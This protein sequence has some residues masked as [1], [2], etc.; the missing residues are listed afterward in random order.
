VD[1]LSED[2]VRLP[3]LRFFI[4][5]RTDF[6]IG[7]AF[8]SQRHILV[9]EL[10]VASPSNNDDIMTFFKDRMSSIR[11]RR[12]RLP[13]ASDWPGEDAIRSLTARAA[14]L[15]LFAATATALIDTH[16]P[17][18]TLQNI[19]RDSISSD[20]QSALDSLYIKALESVGKWDD[21][22]FPTAFRAIVGTIVVAKNPLSPDTIDKLLSLDRMPSLY[23]I[24]HLGCVLLHSDAF[25]P[26][27]IV[28][29]S[30]I[31]FLTDLQ[32]CKSEKW[33]INPIVHNRQFSLH[34]LDYLDR[35]M[36]RN[37][38]NL[39]LSPAITNE[40]IAD[41]VTLGPEISYACT[42]WIEHICA[43]SDRL[44]ECSNRLEPFMQRHFL[45][46]LEAM[47]IL[48]KSRATIGLLEALLKWIHVRVISFFYTHVDHLVRILLGAIAGCLSWLVTP[49]GLQRHLFTPSKYIRC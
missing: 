9:R 1:V 44:S 11:A 12:K 13:L 24:E 48:Q 33:F 5:S 46:W 36:R 21:V 2:T 10:N 34:C 28:H 29:P 19:L 41:G 32:R 45:H 39:I 47:S 43:I 15:F 3:F 40:M 4:T 30:F 25:E 31:D 38:C 8:E 7:Y 20:A 23:T 27:R 35:V 49:I 22:Y 26:V 42:F 17:E 14:G 37:I 16:D 6:N 18:S